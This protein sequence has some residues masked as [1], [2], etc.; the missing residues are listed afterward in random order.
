MT[1][2]SF[3]KRLVPSD[4]RA[5]TVTGLSLV[6]LT[7]IL[8]SPSP[9]GLPSFSCSFG[10]TTSTVSSTPSPTRRAGRPVTGQASGPF[11]AASA[12][13]AFLPSFAQGE[14][15]RPFRRDQPT[16]TAQASLACASVSSL[17]SSTAT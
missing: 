7:V 8:Y 13:H 5:G 4:T 3:H 16:G 2:L 1:R 6:F 14:A 17:A 9:S 12:G 15:G 11:A 10:G